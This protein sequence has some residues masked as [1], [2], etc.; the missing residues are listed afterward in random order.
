LAT[1][2]VFNV[3]LSMRNVNSVSTTL[4]CSMQSTW[5]ER[6]LLCSCTLISGGG[7]RPV[8]LSI[9]GS[10]NTN[11]ISCALC[12]QQNHET[13]ENRP[14]SYCC[15][16]DC[17]SCARNKQKERLQTLKICYISNRYQTNHENLSTRYETQMS[18]AERHYT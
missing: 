4:N 17:T 15:T 16:L 12:G 18:H 6:T 14:S 13:K 10:R 8:C 2:T 11:I 3:S 5:K 7:L 9:H 1:A